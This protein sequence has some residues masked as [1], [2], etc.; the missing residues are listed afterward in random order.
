MHLEDCEKRQCFVR[1]H[2]NEC[3]FSFNL[4]LQEEVLD[5]PKSALFFFIFEHIYSKGY[6][7]ACKNVY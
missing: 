7:A 1:Y 6:I 2:S 3:P 5:N 4:Y